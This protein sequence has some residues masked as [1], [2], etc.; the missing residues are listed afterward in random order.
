MQGVQK[1]SQHCR[2][3][4]R[5]KISCQPETNIKERGEVFFARNQNTCIAPVLTRA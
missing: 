5:A 2:K 3:R 1:K 4:S